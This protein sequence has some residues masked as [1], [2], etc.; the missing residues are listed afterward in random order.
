MNENE[1]HEKMLII[2]LDFMHN[3]ALFLFS[4]KKKQYS[5]NALC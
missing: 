4:N 3:Y 5:E 1:I 2:E